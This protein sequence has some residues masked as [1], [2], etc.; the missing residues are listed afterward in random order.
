MPT[1]ASDDIDLGDPALVMVDGDGGVGVE[2]AQ[3]EGLE[4][5]DLANPTAI[6]TD[7]AAMAVEPVASGVGSAA[8]P[9]APAAFTA[10]TGA[11]HW[12]VLIRA[13]AIETQCYVL[14]ANQGLDFEKDGKMVVTGVNMRAGTVTMRHHASMKGGNPFADTLAAAQASLVAFNAA[15]AKATEEG[16]KER[17]IISAAYRAESEGTEAEY[18]DRRAVRRDAAQLLVTALLAAGAWAL[19]MH[20]AEVQQDELEQVRGLVPGDVR[21]EHERGDGDALV[22]AFLLAGT[23]QREHVRSVVWNDGYLGV[24]RECR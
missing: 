24:G 16:L 5:E 4:D 3:R 23:A 6:A 10:V 14:A 1:E 13:R 18:Y 15:A 21:P 11:A 19:A 9:A 7:A 8:V 22:H 17:N 2:D 20:M 12:Q